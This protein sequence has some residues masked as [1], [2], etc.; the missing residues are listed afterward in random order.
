MQALTWS[1]DLF[2]AVKSSKQLGILSDLSSSN[3]SAKEKAALIGVVVGKKMEA[4][5]IVWV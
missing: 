5:K 3:L 2:E 1:P 4:I